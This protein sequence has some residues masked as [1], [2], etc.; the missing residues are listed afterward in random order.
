MYL[1]LPKLIIFRKKGQNPA[2]SR[3]GNRVLVLDLIQIKGGRLCLYLLLD[4]DD[5]VCKSNELLT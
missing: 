1:L 3:G 5:E 4:L 2:P